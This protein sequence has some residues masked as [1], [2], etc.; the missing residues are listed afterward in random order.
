MPANRITQ[1]EAE[2]FPDVTHGSQSAI[3]EFLFIRNKLLQ[4][5]LQDPL[6]ELT[7]ERAQ[8]AILL[9]QSGAGLA[10]CSLEDTQPLLLRKEIEFVF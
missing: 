5:W 10:L 4:M 2:F 8:S 3:L 1:R 9:P 7:T 6:N